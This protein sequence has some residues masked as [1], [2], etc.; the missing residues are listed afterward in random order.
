MDRHRIGIIGT[1]HLAEVHPYAGQQRHPDRLQFLLMGAADDRAVKGDVVLGDRPVVP[2]GAGLV[3]AFQDLVPMPQV[4]VVDVGEE[5][6][7]RER[8]DAA[9]DAH[10]EVA[11]GG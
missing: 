3:Q 4:F 7:Q 1:L 8:L 2:G 6:T 5:G 9:T 10:G 11:D